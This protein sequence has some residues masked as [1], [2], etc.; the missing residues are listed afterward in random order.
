MVRREAGR[1]VVMALYRVASA[2]AGWPMATSRPTASRTHHKWHNLPGASGSCGTSGLDCDT[3]SI[4]SSSWACGVTPRRRRRPCNRTRLRNVSTVSC[5]VHRDETRRARHTVEIHIGYDATVQWLSKA[6]TP[7]H[8][9]TVPHL[10]SKSYETSWGSGN[11]DALMTTL[12]SG[13]NK[14]LA[15]HR[16]GRNRDLHWSCSVCD[17]GGQR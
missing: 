17:D 15:T 7:A 16:R 14:S 12:H 3:P 10:S 2:P 1:R 11:A 4:P 13:G 8:V 9:G 5:R 6:A